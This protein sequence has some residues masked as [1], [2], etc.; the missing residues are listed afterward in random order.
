[1]KV[2]IKKDSTDIFPHLYEGSVLQHVEKRGEN[3]YGVF[4]SVFGSYYVEVPKKRCK[5]YKEKETF[6]GRVAEWLRR[7][8]AKIST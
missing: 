2:L 4:S 5:K 6:N 7:N 3:Y 8:S 1:M